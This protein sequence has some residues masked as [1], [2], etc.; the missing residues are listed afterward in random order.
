MKILVI[1]GV[2]LNML[3]IRE[4]NLYG[5]KDYKALIKF[6]KAKAKAKNINFDSLIITNERHNQALVD[7]LEILDKAIL[8]CQSQTADIV[9]LLAKNVWKTLGKITGESEV[10][11]IIDAIFSKFCLGK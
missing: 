9:D 3:G 4:K 5:D 1:N 10:E 2:N 6:I 8:A 11:N 7:A